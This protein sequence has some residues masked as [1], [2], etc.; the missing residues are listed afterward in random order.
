MEYSKSKSNNTTLS[1]EDVKIDI[2]PSKSHDK[3]TVAYVNISFPIQTSEEDIKLKIDG[4]RIMTDSYKKNGGGFHLV[5]PCIKSG[6]KYKEIVFIQGRN[7]WQQLE[8]KVL[9]Q[10][11]EI[12]QK[13]PFGNELFI[14]NEL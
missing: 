9:D 14:D 8:N 7:F 3:T 4:Y 11:R 13:E 10:Y 2:H 5:A 12:L 6:D 1:I